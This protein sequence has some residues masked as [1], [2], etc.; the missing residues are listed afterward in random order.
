MKAIVINLLHIVDIDKLYCWIRIFFIIHTKIDYF[1][2]Y[3][4]QYKIY[5]YKYLALKNSS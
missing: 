5:N 3:V 4:I 1:L 2:T